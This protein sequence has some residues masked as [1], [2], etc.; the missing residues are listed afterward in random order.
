MPF[1]YGSQDCC[2][3]AC[4]AIRVMTRVDIAHEFRGEYSTRKGAMEAARRIAGK[5]SI[6]AIVDYVTTN[7]SMLEVK[8]TM[9]QRGDVALIRRS[10]RDH[11]LGIVSLTGRAIVVP[12]KDGTAE[13]A[14]NLAVAG[15]HV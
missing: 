9:L 7:F 6:R 15:W 12:T 2:L 8:P 3:F 5:P 1:A 14:L 4:D 10:N 11:S 13:V